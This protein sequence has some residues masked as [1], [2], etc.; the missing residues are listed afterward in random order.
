MACHGRRKGC[1]VG[2][3]ARGV[4]EY[5]DFLEGVGRGSRN[6]VLCEVWNGGTGGDK[7]LS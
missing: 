4:R 3:G 2:V 6:A 5:A 7:V 1:H